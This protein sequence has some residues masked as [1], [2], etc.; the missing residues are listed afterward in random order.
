MK[1]LCLILRYIWSCIV[2]NPMKWINS[3]M[4]YMKPLYTHYFINDEDSKVDYMEP[5]YNIA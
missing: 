2:R 5:L 3:K 1:L 4:D